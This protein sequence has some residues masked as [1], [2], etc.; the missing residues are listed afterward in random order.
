MKYQVIPEYF[1]ESEK[2]TKEVVITFEVPKDST[3]DETEIT[4]LLKGMGG[5]HIH[6]D[7]ND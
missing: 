4:T 5:T 7:I 3:I 1:W 6:I 2:D